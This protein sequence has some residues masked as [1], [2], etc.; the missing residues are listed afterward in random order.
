MESLLG[1]R[2]Q[3]LL[4]THT[5]TENQTFYYACEPHVS[6]KMHGEIVVGDGGADSSSDT[7]QTE[8]APGFVASTMVVAILGAVL[9]LGRRRS[10]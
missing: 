4:S 10:F 5:F 9:F 6:M 2:Q 3:P 8:D 7:E 1:L